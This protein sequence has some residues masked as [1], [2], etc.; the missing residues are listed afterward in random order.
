[1]FAGAM[2]AT[3]GDASFGNAVFRAVGLGKA[4]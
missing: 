4:C 3:S 2:A 1:L